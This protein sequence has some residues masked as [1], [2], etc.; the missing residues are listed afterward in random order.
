MINVTAVN[1]PPGFTLTQASA[2]SENFD[3]VTVPNLP[4]G[5]TTTFSPTTAKWTSTNVSSDSAPNAAFAPNVN[6][7]DTSLF[8]PVFAVPASGS[9]LTFRHSY[10]LESYY[11]GG[12]LEIA[13]AGGA[14]LG[15]TNQ[16]GVFVSGGYN[17]LSG[18]L[19]QQWSSDS[20]GFITTTVLLPP[21]ASGQNVQLRWRLRSDSSV[22][23]AGWYVDTINATR[24][25]VVT[26]AEDSGSYS[27]PNFAASISVGPANESSQVV[28]FIAT[29]SNNALFSSQPAINAAGTL[30]FTPAA[31]AN[32]SAVVSVQIHDDGGVVNGGVDTSAMQTFTITVT[33]VND[34]PSIFLP[35]N[36]T[37]H[38]TRLLSVTATGTDPE[39][40]ANTLTFGLVSGPVGLNVASSGL[41]TWTPTDANIGSTN[42]RVRVFD[43][44]TPSLSATGTFTVTVVSRPVL[45]PPVFTDGTNV[46]LTW[47]AYSGGLYRLQ[48]LPALAPT[49]ASNWLTLAGDVT[50]TGSFATK[51]HTNG[52][53]AGTNRIFY[54]VLMP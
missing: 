46:V 33:A 26:V 39:Q 22:T 48:Y 31:N 53:A 25:P 13:I 21:A 54:R 41:I 14:F 17:E 37:L 42:V 43:S 34:A 6:S 20:G 23:Y 40:P 45:S 16:G 7:E 3:S 38:A 11:D 30:T 2:L 8:S 10:S 19:G 18:R 47:S 32:G 5:W 29:N 49:N 15:I 12:T 44:G 52:Q 28:N 51:V 35:A 4:A 36:Q 27:Q 1:D 9:T 24:P 50:A